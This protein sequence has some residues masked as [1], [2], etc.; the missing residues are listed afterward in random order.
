[1]PSLINLANG[2]SQATRPKNVGQMSDLFQQFR[3]TCDSHDV[4]DWEKYYN[5]EDKIKEATEKNWKYIQDI[6]KILI[7]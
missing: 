3:E 6:K 2:I 4:T 5:G 1:M 7:S